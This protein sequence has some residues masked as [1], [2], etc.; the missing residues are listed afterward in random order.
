MILL[1]ITSLFFIAILLALIAFYMSYEAVRKSPSRELKKRLRALA[2]RSDERLPSDITME[3]LLEMKPID[4]LLYKARIIRNLDKLIDNAGLKIDLKLFIFFTLLLGLVGFAF[5][6]LLGRGLVFAVLFMLAGLCAPLIYL[7]IKKTKRIIQFTEQFPNALDMMS[8]S[9][10]AGHSLSAAVQMI[11]SEMSDPI[12]SLFKTAYDE[13]TLGLSM[14]AALGRILERINSMDLRLFVTAVNIYVEVGGNFS[15]MLERLAHT[16]RER[17]KI[18]RQIRV[19]TAQARISG[20]I[21]AAL[22]IFMAGALYIIAPDY[23]KELVE[24]KAGKY[25]I[26]AA[27]SAQIVGFLII[28]SLI[29]IR[30]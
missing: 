22:P 5:G 25:V 7:R 4:K 12:A 16:I 27:V 29:N 19:Y 9:L 30:I 28:K 11:G 14:K 6:I 3:I 1:F 26:A 17:L 21:L 8:R 13:Q 2:V 10:K 24:Y 20:Y 23:I 15:E 18:R